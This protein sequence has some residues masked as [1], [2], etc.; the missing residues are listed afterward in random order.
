METTEQ[1]ATGA[2]YSQ[3]DLRAAVV[4]VAGERSGE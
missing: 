1:S 3:S 2:A 4:L